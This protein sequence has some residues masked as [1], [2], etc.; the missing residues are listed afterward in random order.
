MELNSSKFIK[1]A[2]IE[3]GNVL[4]SYSKKGVCKVS[5]TQNGKFK[6]KTTGEGTT[7][8]TL[9][10][11]DTREVIG[12]YTISVNDNFITYLEDFELKDR[13]YSY[14]ASLKADGEKVG[15][16]TGILYN[17]GAVSGTVTFMNKK[18]A[19]YRY[20]DSVFYI[21]TDLPT[22]IL[23]EYSAIIGFINDAGWLSIPVNEDEFDL[24]GIEEFPVDEILA[25]IDSKDLVTSATAYT[26]KLD[27]K[28]LEEISE[29][30]DNTT[31]YTYADDTAL[32]LKATPNKK[33]LKLT[34]NAVADGASAV[35]SL[36]LTEQKKDYT[37]KAP[38]E[39][40]PLE[41]FFAGAMDN[42]TTVTPPAEITNPTT[43]S[44]ETPK[45]SSPVTSW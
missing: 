22:D 38:T 24:T 41:D 44:E 2:R 34:A 31:E 16:V 9:Y 39:H 6:V 4:V 18:V 12:K 35:V 30:V 26:L 43:P 1:N 10:A 36:V 33:G 11:K 25:C 37:L 27:R 40:T 23:P 8:V 45:P 19:K 21:D 5:I 7:K 32:T 29:V 15:S 13:D 42:P 20:V 28:D 3:K 14:T 17:E